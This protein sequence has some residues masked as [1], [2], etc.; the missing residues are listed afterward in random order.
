MT[1]K[2]WDIYQKIGL[3]IGYYRK[4]RGYTQAE[5]AEVIGKSATFISAIEAVN[6]NKAFSMDTFFDIAKALDIEPYKLLKED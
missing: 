4:L 2:R 5:L 3:K 1:E 6:V